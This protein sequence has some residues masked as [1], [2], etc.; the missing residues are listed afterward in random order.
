MS[1]VKPQD[2]QRL[3]LQAVLS[4][5]V[6]SG[7]LA[8]TLWEKSKAA[9]MAADNSLD[10][11]H[12]EDQEEWDAFV[13]KLNQSLNPLDLEFRHLQEETSGR[14]MY[15]IVNRK[16]D[17]IA[18]M[19]TDYTPG[20]IAFF[21]AMV[22]QIMLAPRG[23]YSVSS[24]AALREISALKPKSN[25]SK[26]Q[27]EVVLA[28]FVA[29][30][31]L[32]KSRRGRY[33]LS[34]RA[35]LELEPYLKST[36]PDEI[37]ECVICSETMTKGVACPT[38]NCQVR[39]HYHCFNKWIVRHPNCTTCNKDWPDDATKMTPVG[40]GA[41]REG[42]DVKR[43]VRKVVENSDDE[44]N[45][46]DMDD[47]EPSQ[48]RTQKNR[49]GKGKQAADDSMEIDEEE[50]ISDTPVKAPEKRRSSRR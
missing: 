43:R 1:A 30:G 45:D 35:L 47:E 25:M 15:A 12:S 16:D 32:L 3:F 17:E 36:Y 23:A 7:K 20:E 2:V 5:G 9:V 37:I 10:I 22:E 38:P 34:S 29:K 4:R 33:S 40:E 50:A 42:D 14:V 24:L 49:K 18:Q 39:M 13:A 28:S 27:A 8:Q 44:E 41:A 31:W 26:S 11:P 21:K 48:P 46:E 6:L 19:A